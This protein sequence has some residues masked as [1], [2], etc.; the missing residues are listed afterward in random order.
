MNIGGPTVRWEFTTGIYMLDT[1]SKS[2]S[3]SS[4]GNIETHR[5]NSTVKGGMKSSWV[6]SFLL[7]EGRQGLSVKNQSINTDSHLFVCFSLYLSAAM[8]MILYS[9]DLKA[10]EREMLVAVAVES[11]SARVDSIL[12]WVGIEE[13]KSW[14]THL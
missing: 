5:V 1:D 10:L 6:I 12:G 14:H 4:Q 13:V 3:I 8:G 2:Q 9:E 7:S 11:E